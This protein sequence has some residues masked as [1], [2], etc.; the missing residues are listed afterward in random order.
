MTHNAP[1]L[2]T[3]KHNIIMRLK[4]YKSNIMYTSQAKSLIW[5]SAI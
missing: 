5:F 4:F 3:L 2:T 1:S